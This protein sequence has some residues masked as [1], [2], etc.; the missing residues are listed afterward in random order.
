MGALLGEKEC[1]V[2]NKEWSVTVV[3]AAANAIPQPAGSVVLDKTPGGRLMR[4]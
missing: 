3:A 2:E 1:E 4:E